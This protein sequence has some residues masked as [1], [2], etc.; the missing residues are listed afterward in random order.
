[1]GRKQGMRRCRVFSFSVFRP[2]FRRF[3][4][5]L[6]R[7]GGFHIQTIDII[8][9]YFCDKES[10]VLSILVPPPPCPGR[11]LVAH[12]GERCL[13][14][15]H[16]SASEPFPHTHSM[17]RT[18]DQGDYRNSRWR[19]GGGPPPFTPEEVGGGG[20]PGTSQPLCAGRGIGGKCRAVE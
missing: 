2:N 6:F 1:M 17:D 5:K 15:G 16:L 19:A 7:C 8:K 13:H 12:H 3:K 14:S 20:W 18:G 9:T 10:P 4:N 11:A